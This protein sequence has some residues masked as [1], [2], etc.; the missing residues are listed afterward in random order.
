MVEESTHGSALVLGQMPSEELSGSGDSPS[1]ELL[2]AGM[3]QRELKYPG[4]IGQ[5][6][7]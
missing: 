3:P 5:D 4:V 6:E 2:R 7:T 1:L